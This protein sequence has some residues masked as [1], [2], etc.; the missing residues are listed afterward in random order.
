M[1]GSAAIGIQRGNWAGPALARIR[2]SDLTVERDLVFWAGLAIRIAFCILFIPAIQEMLFIPFMRET[3]LNPSLDPWTKIAALGG[4]ANAFPYGVAMYVAHAPTVAAG[5][6]LDSVLGAEVFTR[7]GFGASLIAADFSLFVILTRLFEDRRKL[8]A[9][10]YWLSPIVIY[11]TYY[12]GQTDVVP[13][14]LLC[15]SL[16][17]LRRRWAKTAGVLLG[18]AVSAKFSMALAAPFLMLYAL[19]NRQFRPHLSPFVLTSLA[20]GV[21]LQAPVLLSDGA[22]RMVFESPEVSRIYA[23]A[24]TAGD[25]RQIYLFFIGYAATV[26]AAFAVRRI[27]FDLL[28]ALLGVGFM[29]VLT[30]APA[31]P[32]WFVWSVPFLVFYQMRDRSQERAVLLVGAYSI[33]FVIEQLLVSSGARAPFFAADWSAPIAESLGGAD[34]PASILATLR[35]LA[36]AVIAVSLYRSGVASN[37]FFRLSRRPVSIGVAGDSGSGKDTLAAALVA[38]FGKESVISVSGDDYHRYERGAPMW[39]ILTHLDPRA[40]DLKSMNADVR[41]LISERDI[42]Q[43]HYDHGTGRF[44]DFTRRRGRDVVIV[45]GLHA[46]YSDSLS[47]LFDAKIFLDMDDD[48]RRALKIRRDVFDRGHDR[49]AVLQSMARRAID[50]DRYILPQRE[51]ADLVFALRAAEGQTIR[52]DQPIDPARLRLNVRWR[53]ATDFTDLSRGLIGLC[54]ARLDQH[55]PGM[56]G[57]VEFDVEGDIEADDI[58]LMIRNIA[59]EAGDLL[60][61]DP[62]WSGGLLGVMQLISVVHLVRRTRQRRMKD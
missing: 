58:G 17:A 57:F 13:V 54:G 53:D 33:L 9:W 44:T 24:L 11:A 22:R 12:H 10:L 56:D 29:T 20:A 35:T 4:P 41:A 48:L 27:N 43:R 6:A 7:L 51:R 30:L 46:L 28:F 49:E 8:V 25:G 42:S 55:P 40:N 34:K 18:F 2:R 1:S 45:S 23:F 14:A 50:R 26:Y 47:D 38:V 39:Q 59:P 19:N 36:G 5:V 61:P 32:G 31:A 21:L 16:L 52:D 60:G 3:L 62:A 15:G 37:D